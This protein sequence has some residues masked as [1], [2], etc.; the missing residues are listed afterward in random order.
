GLVPAG[1]RSLVSSPGGLAARGLALAVNLLAQAFAAARPGEVR[2]FRGHSDCVVSVAIS[3]D[4][5]FGASGSW[6]QT[7]RIWDLAGGREVRRLSGHA[8]R[9]SSVAF[10][11]DGRQLI[12]GSWDG[13][14]RLWDLSTGAEIDQFGT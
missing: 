3:L 2:C 13:T 1:E 12:S 6:D 5:R 4:G 9:V 11:P 8:H 7:V 14:A 10:S